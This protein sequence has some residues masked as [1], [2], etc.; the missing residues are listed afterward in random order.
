M[1]CVPDLGANWRVN[2]PLACDGPTAL[3]NCMGQAGRRVRAQ[4]VP[5]DAQAMCIGQC[6]SD[7]PRLKEYP[8]A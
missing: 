4:Y 7:T 6:P 1:S 8:H 2:R 5:Y 3:D